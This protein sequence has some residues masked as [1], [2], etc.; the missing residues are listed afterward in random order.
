VKQQR[1][2][3]VASL[4]LNNN[5][6]YVARIVFPLVFSLFIVVYLLVYLL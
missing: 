1:V 6:D 2:G 3:N 5:I 4:Q